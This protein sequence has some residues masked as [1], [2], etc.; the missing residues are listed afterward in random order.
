MP[1]SG[2]PS[3]L[4]IGLSGMAAAKAGVA[5]AGHN[6]ANANT[7][8]YSRQKVQLET[9][10]PQ[11]K[12]R[13]TYGAGVKTAGV[14]RTNDEYIT[15]QIRK[16]NR[17]LVQH[18]EK[19]MVLKQVEDVFNEM[20]GDGLNRL[21]AKLFNGFRALS[22]EPENGALRQSVRESTAAVVNEFHRL[23]GE[24]VDVQHHIDARLEAYSREAN[25]IAEQV[26]D[27]NLKIKSIEMGGGSPNDLLDKR[28]LLLKKLGSYVEISV[29]KDE[30]GN[31]SVDMA[32][33]GPWVAGP[34]V[35]KISVN[36]SP[37]DKEGKPEG[38][39]DIHSE[40]S[41]SSTVTHRLRG[42]KMGAL[43]EARDQVLSTV[44]NRLDDLAYGMVKSINAI[45]KQG[46]TNEGQTD[47]NFFKDLPQKERAA[48]FIDL[49]DAIRD[50][51]NNIATGMSASASGD[52]RVM[53]ALSELQNAKIMNNGKS[54]MDD[55]YDSI[56]SDVGVASASNREGMNQ[57]KDILNQ[58]NKMHDQVSGVSIDEETTN[59]MQFQHAY[60]ASA[61][62]IQVADEL[63]KTVLDM[64]K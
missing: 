41:L 29:H 22:N 46:V 44:L 34:E 57:Q 20:G 9:E 54:T 61:K 42:G 4:Q 1:A 48:E 15:R 60:D 30:Q 11:Q 26:K 16:A 40:S 36:R 2:L 59:L 27:L 19:D 62:V 35:N 25:S 23:R 18:Q 21:V 13:I 50:N 12:G 51:V 7:E 52:N 56:V 47:V 24:V 6:I 10:R 38:A 14:F 43:L 45:H 37:A 8:G 33:V 32:G 3:V 5:T 64:K 17:E 28:D 53:L 49:S 63:L 31:V 58:L 55:W 39:L